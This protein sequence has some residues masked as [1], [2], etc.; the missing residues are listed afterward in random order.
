MGN[1][2]PI[3][4]LPGPLSRIAQGAGAPYEIRGA[5]GKPS[6]WVMSL[7]LLHG[8]RDECLPEPSLTDWLG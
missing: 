1:S 2:P 4:R 3:R 8:F 5:S 6:K 7:T